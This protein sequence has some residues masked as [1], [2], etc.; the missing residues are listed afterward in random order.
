MKTFAPSIKAW[1]GLI[2][3]LTLC[4]TCLAQ[5]HSPQPRIACNE[6]QF[7]F[8]SALNS[9]EVAHDFEIRNA[10]EAPLIISQI[11]SGCGCTRAL[12]DRTTIEPGG[13]AVLSTHLT[14]RG[15]VGVKRTNIYLHTNDPDKPVFHCLLTG[16]AVTDLAVAPPQV[17]FTFTSQSQPML[18]RLV[19]TGQSASTTRITGLETQGSFFE[20]LIDTKTPG[21]ATVMVIPSTNTPSESLTGMV[22]ISTDHPR[23]RKVN[24]PIRSSAAPNPPLN[25]PGRLIPPSA[26]H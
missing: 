7:D 24:V 2:A 12:I 11:R 22:I 6:P 10:G 18:Q 19:L 8:G 5:T 23:F 25:P 4:G 21:P 9:S 3:C 16:T 26:P 15:I 17:V 14:L 13:H 20:A 1:L